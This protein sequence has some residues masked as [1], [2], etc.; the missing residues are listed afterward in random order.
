MTGTTAIAVKGARL[1]TNGT[2]TRKRKSIPNLFLMPSPAPLSVNL[3]G[4]NSLN[5]EPPNAVQKAWRENVRSYGSI[6]SGPN[7]YPCQIH[8]PAGRKAKHQ[9]IAIGH[10][11]ILPLAPDEH[12]KIDTGRT[13]LYEIKDQ[14]LAY[15][16]VSPVKEK[17]ILDMTLHEF[18][19]FLF[20]RLCRTVKFPFGAAVYDAI[21]AWHR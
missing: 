4:M 18:E 15:Q 13:G 5:F 2:I 10:A 11:W 6:L 7:Y 1:N 3:G 16:D 20:A 8:H 14:F 21:Q 9:K 19:K 12:K 17:L